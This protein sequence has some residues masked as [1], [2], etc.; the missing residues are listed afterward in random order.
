MC[1]LQSLWS[2]ASDLGGDGGNTDTK[3]GPLCLGAKGGAQNTRHIDFGTE[4][5]YQQYQLDGGNSGLI[6]LSM[7]WKPVW[8][9]VKGVTERQDAVWLA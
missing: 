9:I 3:I 8:S 4:G 6:R 2:H 1:S 5:R 7:S